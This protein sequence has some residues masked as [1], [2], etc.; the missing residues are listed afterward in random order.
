M[1][2]LVEQYQ[3]MVMSLLYKK[4]NSLVGVDPD[5]LVSRVALEIEKLKKYYHKF[6]T[7]GNTY[8]LHVAINKYGTTWTVDLKAHTCTCCEWQI[9]GIPCIHAIAV[10]MPKRKSLA[11]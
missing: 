11:K 7:Q 6:T 9:N 4:K 1:I 2:K 3:I 8:F 5:A 10:I